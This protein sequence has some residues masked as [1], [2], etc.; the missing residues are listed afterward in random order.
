MIHIT[1]THKIMAI[2]MVII[3]MSEA[4]LTFVLIFY[5]LQ[6][7]T[8]QGPTAGSVSMFSYELINCDE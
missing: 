7:Q 6:K 4:D 3:F 1:H 2:I 5:I 8:Y